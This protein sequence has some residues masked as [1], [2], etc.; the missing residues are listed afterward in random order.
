MTSKLSK[1]NFGLVIGLAIFVVGSML[2]LSA[3]PSMDA[4]PEGAR[5]SQSELVETYTITE[6]TEGW[7]INA[8]GRLKAQDELQI[9]AEVAGKVAWI[10]PRMLAGGRFSEGDILFKIDP[11]TYQN[12]ALRAAAAVKAA[13]AN[14]SRLAAAKSRAERLFDQ[15]NISE[16][17]LDAASAALASAEADLAQANAAL[18][19][20]NELLTR[21]EIKAPFNAIVVSESVSLDSYVAPGQSVA[22]LMSSDKAEMAISLQRD[23]MD[24]IVKTYIQSGGKPLDVIAM[25][26]SGAISSLSLSGQLKRI[27][28][29]VDR[30]SRTATII[31]EFDDVFTANNRGQIFGD[32]FMRI[33]I[34]VVSDAPLW[35]IPYGAIRGGRFVWVVGDDNRIHSQA[36]EV[37]S[38]DGR[39]GIVSSQADL[40]GKRL[41]LTLLAEEI[42]GKAVRLAPP[43]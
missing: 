9:V 25:P 3:S 18:A 30:Q 26:G 20:A 41:M 37:L 12:D 36:V 31:A 34:K 23:E 22:H 32:D 10:D 4:A 35:E 7:S 17:S 21:T 6:S 16:A 11:V 15:G 40:T 43:Q 19:T 8:E 39:S 24:A 29:I 13:E 2:A 28:P 33:E 42:D 14:L 1:S 5:I 27:S 38:T